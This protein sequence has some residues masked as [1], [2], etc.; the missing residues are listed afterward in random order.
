MRAS[1][2]A[3]PCTTGLGSGAAGL[4]SGTGAS[5]PA[6]AGT[7]GAGGG[8]AG[9]GSAGAGLAGVV[10][11]FAAPLPDAGG[12]IPAGWVGPASGN[13]GSTMGRENNSPSWPQALPATQKQAAITLRRA[14]RRYS[15]RAFG[16]IQA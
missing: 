14:I 9:A 8:S 13:T 6:S 4:A 12:A 15:G 3:A 16:G 11:A 5:T 10:G 7:A 2:A 1:S